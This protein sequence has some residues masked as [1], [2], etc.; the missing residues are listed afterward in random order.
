MASGERPLSTEQI[1][2][3]P[4]DAASLRDVRAFLRERAEALGLADD[5]T[6]DLL[7]AVVEACTNVVRHSGAGE[8]RLRWRVDAGRI[9]VEIEDSGVFHHR[10]PDPD[11]L[12]GYGIPLMH[13]LM[14][15]VVILRGDQGHPGTRVFMA[16]E[17]AQQ[18]HPARGGHAHSG[19][20]SRRL[21]PGTPSSRA[22]VEAPSGRPRR[23]ALG[24]V[25]AAS[26]A[27]LAAA[28]AFAIG[29]ARSP[30]TTLTS[31]R[32]SPSVAYPA[33]SA[34][35]SSHAPASP[36]AHPSPSLAH[37]HTAG[38]TPSAGPSVVAPTPDASPRVPRLVLPTLSCPDNPLLGIADAAG[39]SVV[40]TCTWAV[41]MVSSVSS[42]ALG[43]RVVLHLDP[44]S[45]RLAHGGALSVLILPG[46][47]LPVPHVGDRLAALGTL[48]HPPVGAS[49]SLQ[50]AWAFDDL[51]TG[52]VTRALPPTSIA[53]PGVCVPGTDLCTDLPSPGPLPSLPTVS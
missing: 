21:H 34:H 2:S 19:P 10:P 7:I 26:V 15:E 1:R 14:D 49:R 37:R 52:T 46:Q 17:V 11:R 5:I 53:S 42:G 27:A 24:L 44:R 39:I 31:G 22:P 18:L 25:A 43:T 47:H 3:F 38:P 13:S 48:I 28:G 30:D 8:M 50:P 16:K 4:A 36:H 12:G 20:R 9:E 51:E 40:S 29:A 6:S 41:G 32:G 23:F 35:L 45:R 33:P